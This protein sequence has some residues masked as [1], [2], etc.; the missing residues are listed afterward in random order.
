[1]TLITV[2]A[3]A[4]SVK[5]VTPVASC[6]VPNCKDIE[7]T[8]AGRESSFCSDE[9]FEEGSRRW[10]NCH[11]LTN[12][13]DLAAPQRFAAGSATPLLVLTTSVLWK[14]YLPRRLELCDGRVSENRR[15]FT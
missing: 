11:G 12:S 5:G 9:V 3:K 13:F 4:R 8:R 14:L 2:A 6:T 1:M 7:L 10:Q 15:S